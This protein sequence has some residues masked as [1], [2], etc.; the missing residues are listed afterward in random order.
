MAEIGTIAREW[1]GRRTRYPSGTDI[2][3]LIDLKHSQD[4]AISV[5]LPA[6]NE[7]ATIG[8]ICRA[9]KKELMEAGLVDQIVVMDSRST[10]QTAAIARR[11]GAEVRSVTEVL[12][13]VPGFD[14]GKGEALWK[15]LA[16]AEGDIV[17]WVDSDTRNFTTNFVTWLLEPL[18]VDRLLV[19]SK[20]FYDRPLVQ[21]E[22]MMASGGAR[23]TELVA[24]PLLNLFYPELAGVIQPLSGEYAVRANAARS[25]PFLSGYAPDIGLLIWFAEEYGIDQMVQV[26]LGTRIHRNQDILALGRM[27]HQVMQ[28]ML[29]AFDHFG[30][31]KLVDDPSTSHAQFLVAEGVQTVDE[32]DL[33]VVELPRMNSL[34]RG[35]AAD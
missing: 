15:S 24:R 25:V 23:V 3:A 11:E 27:G 7:E 33:T 30:R 21:G 13:D 8:P 12:P 19:L 35:D 2:E 4:V 14:G 34:L 16:V 31:V 6:R 28:G 22:T 10:D 26:D 18:L 5:C 17:V 20:A 9:L 32:F 1:L 29:R